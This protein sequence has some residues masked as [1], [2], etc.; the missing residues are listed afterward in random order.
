MCPD[1]MYIHRKF[2]HNSVASM[3]PPTWESR[4]L[5]VSSLSWGYGLDA[6]RKMLGK[7]KGNMCSLARQMN[8]LRHREVK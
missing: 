3:H 1:K 5:I 2:I 6:F 7:V 4:N 8:M